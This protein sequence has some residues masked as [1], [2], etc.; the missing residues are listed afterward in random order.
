MQVA[1]MILR[2]TDHVD[3]KHLDD[4]F[5]DSEADNF[6]AR[7]HPFLYGFCKVEV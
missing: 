2:L 6:A 7:F 3:A 5:G 1:V 4:D